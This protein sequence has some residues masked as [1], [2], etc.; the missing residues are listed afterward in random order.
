VKI[1][2]NV[3]L[4]S[5]LGA[6]LGASSALSQTTVLYRIPL[7]SNPGISAWYDHDSRTNFLLR[8]D[9]STNFPYDGHHGTD[10]PISKGTTIVSGA[11]GSV[12]YRFDGCYDYGTPGTSA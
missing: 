6:L 4:L 7:S 10:F 9:G 8:Y 11:T 5:I 12:Y 2:S 3:L 1:N